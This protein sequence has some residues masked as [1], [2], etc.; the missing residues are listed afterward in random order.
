MHN[1]AFE[2]PTCLVVPNNQ[3]RRGVKVVRSIA[4]DAGSAVNLTQKLNSFAFEITSRAAFGKRFKDQEAFISIVKEALK[5]AGGFNVADLY[6]SMEWLHNVNGLRSKLV[7]IHEAA[8][9][10]MGIMVN[11]HKMHK[12][13]GKGRED[14][15]LVDALLEYHECGSNDSVVEWKIRTPSGCTCVIRAQKMV[16]GIKHD[17]RHGVCMVVHRN[18]PLRYCCQ[19]IWVP[20]SPSLAT[21]RRSEIPI[22]GSSL[23]ISGHI[24]WWGRDNAVTV[25]WAMSEMMKNP[26][27]MEKAQDEVRHVFDGKANVDETG[28]G[29]LEYLKLVIK[30]TLRFRSPIPLLLP[31][32]CGERGEINGCEIPEKAKIMVNQKRSEPLGWC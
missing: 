4:L 14:D 26:T 12:A 22:I 29:E 18:K 13:S 30:E 1:R 19:A 21:E 11:E 20:E 24:H 3:T 27:I 9:R 23:P 31:R 2:P 8:D 16:Y 32:V 15:D 25:D 17:E 28:L 5:L 6:P 7:K 10:I